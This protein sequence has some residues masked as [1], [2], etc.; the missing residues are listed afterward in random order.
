MQDAPS[1]PA[2]HDRLLH[3]AASALKYLT[4]PAARQA[5]FRKL[6]SSTLPSAEAFRAF[7]ISEASLSL[8]DASE[9]M[10]KEVYQTW[11]RRDVVE[12]SLQWAGWL[13]RKG[14]GREASDVIN[15][16]RAEVAMR[17]DLRQQLEDGWLSQLKDNDE[18]EAKSGGDEEMT[19]A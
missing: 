1:F 7:F 5:T 19:D 3:E 16:A 13:V 17:D 8:Q 18:D 10:L 4:S 15:S 12:A 6:C 11:R 9:D 14:R 2:V